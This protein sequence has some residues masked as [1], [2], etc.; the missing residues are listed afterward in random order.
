MLRRLQSIHGK[1]IDAQ[2]KAAV[3]MTRGMM[4]QKHATDGTAILPASQIDLFI[5]DKDIQPTGLMAYEGEISDYDS[6]LNA[7]A[8]NDYVLLEKPMIGE[9]WATDMY[10]ATNLVAG[11]YAEVS[12]AG[13]ATQGKMIYKGSA[14]EF[15]YIGTITEKTGTPLAVFEVLAPI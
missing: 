1:N 10:V 4:V 7:I 5:V 13:D 9:R 14:S 8:A 2:K 3:A 12:T 15:R 11:C 6:R